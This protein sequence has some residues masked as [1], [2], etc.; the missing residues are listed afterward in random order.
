MPATAGTGDS[1]AVERAYTY[2][3]EQR[4]ATLWYHDPRMGFTGPNVWHGLAGFHL[5]HDDEEEALP[6]PRGAPAA[7]PSGRRKHAS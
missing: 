7:V 2:P 1:V 5:V 4:A 6:L 3:M